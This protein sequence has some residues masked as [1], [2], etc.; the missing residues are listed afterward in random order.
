MQVPAANHAQ[1]KIRN[2][3]ANMTQITSTLHGTF[4]APAM[5]LHR[6]AIHYPTTTAK[7]NTLQ[8]PPYDDCQNC[9]HGK[10]TR[11]PFPVNVRTTPAPLDI[12]STDTAGP[13]PRS[14]DNARYLQ[15]IHDRATC[16]LITA[17]LITKSAAT[18]AIQHAI[19]RLQLNTG[20]T[21]RRYH[22]DN[23]REQHAEPLRTFLLNQGTK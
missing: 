12:I 20:R 23:A 14:H 21:V 1:E 16:Y 22:A 6:I 5:T 13:L 17:P 15:L 19:V 7:L 10:L 4:N 18:A 11:A 8:A 9:A 2:V 3:Q